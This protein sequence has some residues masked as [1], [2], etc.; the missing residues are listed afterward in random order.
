MIQH[1]FFINIQNFPGIDTLN[2]FLLSLK[3]KIKTQ[4]QIIRKN[5]FLSWNISFNFLFYRN[6]EL[7]NKIWKL[8]CILHYHIIKDYL[9]LNVN[10]DWLGQLL[11]SMHLD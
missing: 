1:T 5:V 6:Y 7:L 3:F 11:S 4:L 10:T 9:Y 2:Y 8:Y